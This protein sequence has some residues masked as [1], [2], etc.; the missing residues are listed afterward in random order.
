MKKILILL[1][2]TLLFNVTFADKLILINYTGSEEL[3]ALHAN[4]SLKIYY[5]VENFIIASVENDYQG[6]YTFLDD[7]CWSE[8]Q[9]YYIAWFHKGIKDDYASKISSITETLAETDNYLI[10]STDAYTKIHPPIDGR[11][12]KLHN[13]EI[14]LPEKNFQYS[15]GSLF[16]NPNIEEMMEN[17][18]TNIFLTNLQHLQDYGTRNAYSPEAVEAQNWIKEQF[19]S[20]GYD[21]EL[22][23]FTMPNGPASDNV[24][25]TKLGTKYPDEYVILGGH[26]DSYSW[27]GNAPGA[28]DDGTGTCGVMEVA[29]VMADFQTDRTVI[30]CAWSGEEYG[31]YGSEAY[32]EWAAGEGLNILGYFNIDMCGYRHPG[33]QIHT[34]MIAPS[35]AQ[36][37]VD[38]Y[39]EVCELYLPDF[40]IDM[41]TLIG[42]DSDHT[43]FNNNGYMGIFPFED[44][45]NYSPYI[46][47]SN[48]VIGISVNSLEMCM[49]FTQAMVANVATMAN[50]PE[51]EIELNTGFQFISSNR[52][53]QNPD[54]LDVLQNNLNNNLDFVRDSEGTMVRKIGPNWVNGIGD[55][56]SVEGYLF[57]MNEADILIVNGTAVDPQTSI[58]LTA[59]FQFVSYLPTETL[60][61]LEAFNNILTDNLDYIRNSN[62]S[63]L[64]KIGPNW[65]NGLGDVYPGEGYLIKMFSSDI[66]IYNITENTK[67]ITYEKPLPVHFEFEGGNPADPVYTL[68]V[69]GLEIGDEVAA[70]DE[71]K[72]IGAAKISS[73]YVF[74]NE[75]PVFSSLTEGKGYIEGNP[76]IL[77]VWNPFSKNIENIE[78][79]ME[80]IYNAYVG[81]VFPT[82]DGQFSV[83]NITKSI[84]RE[85]SIT[86][87]PNPAE[88]EI[89][90]SSPNQINN[91]TI[92]NYVGQMVYNRNSTR[93]NIA[94][95]DAGVYIIRIETTEGFTTEKL[96]IK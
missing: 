64:R 78:F 1:V 16:L 33:D 28:D 32:A 42:G 10:L 72:L 35:S 31:L 82:G 70:F 14:K 87:Y 24:L 4:Q 53:P 83:V 62:G 89:N 29:R 74:D 9:N 11:I 86:I 84:D 3:K 48:D 71:N 75:L 81:N 91:I 59:G 65:V 76:I 6:N 5:S 21:V 50:D 19:E 18:D 52:Y 49:I 73:N 90:I 8:N 30:F 77:K 23:D 58:E 34:D 94:N 51:Q 40:I 54:M 7:N 92:Y 13:K 79:V 41:G 55:W 80:N 69:S 43:S 46:H 25:A 95:F 38:F 22:F 93:I 60:D 27:S 44:S 66:L 63:V 45:Q 15:K 68:Y 20:Y 12:V 57:K 37:L 47:T 56:V 26:Y 2:A 39:I 61:A 67:S 85:N 88:N 36:P 96:T 17:V